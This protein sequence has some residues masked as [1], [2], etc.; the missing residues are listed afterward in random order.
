VPSRDQAYIGQRVVVFSVGQ[1]A[2]IEGLYL[3]TT[4]ALGFKKWIIRLND[5]NDFL[6]GA[7]TILDVLIKYETSAG[8]VIQIK[9]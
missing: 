5:G 3:G 6:M 7:A 2:G 1:P 4:M 8:T 9:T